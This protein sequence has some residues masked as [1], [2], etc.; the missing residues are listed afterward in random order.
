MR[1]KHSLLHLCFM[2]LF[3]TAC[4]SKMTIINDVDERSANEILVFLAS[5]GIV[6]D[7]SVAA[8]GEGAAVGG[9]KVPLWNIDVEASQATEAMAILNR[10]GLPRPTGQTLLDLFAE[11]GLV[12]TDL[13]EQVRFQ[14]G[15]SEQISGTIRKIDGVLDA[16][17]QISFPA[18]DSQLPITAAVYVKHQ[19]VLDNP[20]SHLVTKIQQL[21][22]G[23]VSGLKL[24]NVTVIA[25]RSRFTDVTLAGNPDEI[26]EEREYVS[27]W[28][29]VLAKESTGKF[30]AI[31][32]T[33]LLLIFILVASL[34]WLVWKIFPVMPKME[35]GWRALIS[36]RPM[37]LAAPPASTEP[38]G[39]G[40]F[41]EELE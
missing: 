13:Q 7:K 16:D 22:A 38:E 3:L 19:G 32:F 11:P 30:R 1:L 40:E 29:V 36:L 41:G 10:N 31:F 15:L 24:E 35:G 12:P 20:N 21:V 23:S 17:V 2:L 34:I 6:A 9:P 27:L 39:P 8:S 28:G 37:S 26:G 14:A 5:K 25:D 4:N 18:A 33:F